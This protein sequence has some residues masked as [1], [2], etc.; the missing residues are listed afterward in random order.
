MQKT[1]WKS[2]LTSSLFVLPYFLLFIIFLL[3]PIVYGAWMSLHNW[4]LLDPV[5]KFV[6]LAN[7][8]KIFDPSSYVNKL[9]FEGLRNTLQFVVYSV[10]LLVLIGLGLALLVNTLPGKIKGLFRTFYFIPYSVS[11]SV[12]GIIWLWLLDTNS[13]LINQYLQKMHIPGI[14]WLTDMPWAWISIVAATLWWTIGFNMVIFINALN[15]VSEE[16]YEAGSLDGANRWQR[17]RHIT[18]PSIKP[19]MIFVIITS[20]IASFNVY[21]Q[22]FLMTRGG[23]GTSTKVLLMNIVDEAFKQR[24]LGTSAAMSLMM[25]LI[26]IIISVIQLKVTRGKE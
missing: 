7:Y 25:A 15:D 11:V 10:P 5:H 8:G 21:G 1:T 14:P 2:Q 13:G 23:P 12:V 20:T 22:P 26:M 16:L 19:T 4:D 18:L 9:F 24:Q 6:G 3:I 17:F